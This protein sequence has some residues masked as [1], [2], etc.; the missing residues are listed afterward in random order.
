MQFYIKDYNENVSFNNN[1]NIIDFK[2]HFYV[3]L[4]T[5]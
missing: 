3:L 2:F 4:Y 5:L 1:F